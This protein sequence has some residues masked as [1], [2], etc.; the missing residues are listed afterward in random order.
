M[1][2]TVAYMNCPN[3]KDGCGF[4]NMTGQIAYYPSPDAYDLIQIAYRRF[5]VGTR[6]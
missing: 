5:R 3:C 4:C 1:I 6:I 2:A